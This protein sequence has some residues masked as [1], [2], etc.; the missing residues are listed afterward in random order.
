MC[1]RC[2]VTIMGSR[3][4]PFSD[5]Q[6]VTFRSYYPMSKEVFFSDVTGKSYV[7]PKKSTNCLW[8]ASEKAGWFAKPDAIFHYS[9]TRKTEKNKYFNKD[10]THHTLP[11]VDN[12]ALKIIQVHNALYR[13]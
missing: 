3:Y 5:R 8:T 12:G 6:N 11:N 13:T 4:P 1:Y 7:L 10:V 9:F 2:D